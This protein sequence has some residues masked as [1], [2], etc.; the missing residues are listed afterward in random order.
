MHSWEQMFSAQQTKQKYS[1]WRKTKG[2]LDYELSEAKW[3]KVTG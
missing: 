3:T 2:F 1:I